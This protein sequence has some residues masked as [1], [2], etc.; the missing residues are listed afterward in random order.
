M[1][2]RYQLN[3]RE[4]RRIAWQRKLYSKIDHHHH[5]NKNI[6]RIKWIIWLKT[7]PTSLLSSACA[8]VI[9]IHNKRTLSIRRVQC[10]QCVCVP[11]THTQTTIYIIFNMRLLL[12][13][14]GLVSFSWLILN[15][16]RGA[17]FYICS[18]LSISFI[19]IY[20]YLLSGISYP[21]ILY[22]KKR[23]PV[24]SRNNIQNFFFQNLLKKF[25]DFSSIWILQDFS[26]I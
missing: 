20:Y 15:T 21:G 22:S 6:T 26:G 10:I 3:R 11:S 12:A 4:K 1:A 2:S 23:V 9:N 8:I 7:N 17:C 5:Q 19:S 18:A 13:F 25:H 16:L 14:Y 24:E